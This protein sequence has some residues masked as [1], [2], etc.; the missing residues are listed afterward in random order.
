MIICYLIVRL[1]VI[2]KKII[3]MLWNVTPCRLANSYRLFIGAAELPTVGNLFTDRHGETFR[4]TC[5][6]IFI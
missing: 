3:K 4:K 6:R 2:V 5:P 1:L